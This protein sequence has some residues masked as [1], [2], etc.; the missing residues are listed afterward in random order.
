MVRV[1]YVFIFF[2]FYKEFSKFFTNEEQRN[3]IYNLWTVK[4]SLL[5][6]AASS[7]SMDPVRRY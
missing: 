3:P 5:A 7:S 2:F 6:M 4:H 1:K